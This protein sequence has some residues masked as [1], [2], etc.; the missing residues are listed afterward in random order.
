MSTML[1]GVPGVDKNLVVIKY[2]VETWQILAGKVE[3]RR[4]A[5]CD[6]RAEA[7]IRADTFLEDEFSRLKKKGTVCTKWELEELAATKISIRKV[8]CLDPEL[9]HQT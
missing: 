6:S 1:A 2:V 9:F 7:K 5:I 4:I 8:R 3:C